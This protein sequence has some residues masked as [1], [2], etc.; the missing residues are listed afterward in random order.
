MTLTDYNEHNGET[1]LPI[2]TVNLQDGEFRKRKTMPN[3]YDVF[4][5]IQDRTYFYI[6][7]VSHKDIE[8][9]TLQTT[10]EDGNPNGYSVFTIPNPE[11]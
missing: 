2:G 4:L 3:Y 6:A 7:E 11:K 8:T 5:I 9:L 1:R 10:D